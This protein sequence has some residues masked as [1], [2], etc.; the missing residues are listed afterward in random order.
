MVVVARPDAGGKGRGVAQEPCVARVIRR[1]CFGGHGAVAQ[2][3]IGIGSENI[4]SRGVVGE[5]I[6]CD[7]GDFGC[8]DVLARSF[9][10]FLQD[11][12]V[13]HFHIKDRNWIAV[14]ALI[15]QDG[16][17]IRVFEKLYL[18]ASEDEGK[19]VVGKVSEGSVAET[20]GKIEGIFKPDEVR[21]FDGWDIERSLE[22][23]ADGDGPVL[24]LAVVFWSIVSDV[25]RENSVDVPENRVRGVA[26]FKSGG[27][28]NGF[29]TRPRLERTSRHIHSSV[30]L[31][32]EVIFGAD[33]GKN[34][35]CLGVDCHQRRV[36]K[37]E[38]FAVCFHAVAN[39]FLGGNLEVVINRGDDLESALFDHA[40]SVGFLELFFDVKDEVR[41]D[42]IGNVE[43]D[44]C[45][46]RK[47]GFIFI[48]GDKP[49]TVHFTQNEIAPIAET[50]RIV[51]VRRRGLWESRKS[52][53]FREADLADRFSEIR[54]CGRFD[55]VVCRAVRN[56]IEVD[57]KDLVFG[58][59]AFEFDRKNEFLHLSD[60]RSFVRED[61]VFDELLG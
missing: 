51:E 1:S 19:A 46:A 33:H 11:L 44:R 6:R 21:Y 24:T 58:I 54:L 32:I 60:E 50:F 55:P 27:I 8:D 45:V 16:V 13:W 29:E 12:A 10:P 22:R 43:A 36:F 52:C 15:R 57:L 59:T 49:L 17:R 31:L 23:L 47:S 38:T 7:A 20:F 41:G 5:H 39:G 4:G 48:F 34:L 25:G 61:G 2:L 37:S 42:D 28:D 56:L 3:E 9:L 18:G 35:S 40:P 53:R 14:D 26:A 30:N